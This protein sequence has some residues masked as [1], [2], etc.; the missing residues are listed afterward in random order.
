M[1]ASTTIQRLARRLKDV[2]NLTVLTNGPDTF[3][4]LQ[5]INGVTRSSPEERSTSAPVVWSDRLPFGPPR[6][7]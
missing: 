3:F 6:T 4:A 1:D 2:S 7:S 5:E